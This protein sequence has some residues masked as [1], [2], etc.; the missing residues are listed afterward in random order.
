[1]FNLATKY[2]FGFSLSRAYFPL[3]S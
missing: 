1:L 2:P 3:M